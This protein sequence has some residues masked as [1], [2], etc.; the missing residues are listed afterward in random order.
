MDRC[1]LIPGAIFKILDL[2]FGF[3]FVDAVGLLDFS[4]QLIALTRDIVEMV[5]R[6]FPPLLFDFAFVLLPITFDDVPIHGESFLIA[7]KVPAGIEQSAGQLA[8]PKKSMACEKKIIG[9]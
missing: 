2:A 6:Q 4:D 7:A 3:I 8:M 1:L 5:V 9:L